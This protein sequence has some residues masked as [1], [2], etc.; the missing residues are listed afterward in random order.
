MTHKVRMY[1]STK[2]NNSIQRDGMLV[3]I[4]STKCFMIPSL[5]FQQREADGEALVNPPPAEVVTLEE[6]LK[7]QRAKKVT[8]KET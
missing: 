1:N 5:D 4:K 2:F 6:A 3:V 8:V 7:S